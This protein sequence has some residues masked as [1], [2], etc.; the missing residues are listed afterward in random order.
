[1]I[2][3][4]AILCPLYN[5]ITVRGI[6]TKLYTIVKHVQMT[7]HAQ[8]PQLLHVYFSNYS[9]CNITKCIFLFLK[10]E[11]ICC[12]FFVKNNSSFGLCLYLKSFNKVCSTV[13]HKIS[14][15]RK[16][17]DAEKNAFSINLLLSVIFHSV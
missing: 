8:E 3:C 11:D 2:I 9:P 4:N 16:R 6:S 15:H 10:G 13:C 5:L 17:S 7:C 12:F 1:M 14:N